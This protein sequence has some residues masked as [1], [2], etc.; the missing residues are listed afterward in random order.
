[1]FRILYITLP[2]T[3]VRLGVLYCLLHAVNH[4]H[5]YQNKRQNLA[6]SLSALVIDSQVNSLKPP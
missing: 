4:R 5:E 1:M 2:L 3:D 6:W